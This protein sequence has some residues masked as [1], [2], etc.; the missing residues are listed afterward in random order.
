MLAALSGFV[1]TST[2]PIA[3]LLWGVLLVALSW[4]LR[5]SK[6]AA[7]EQSEAAAPEEAADSPMVVG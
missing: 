3:I 2:E 4:R 7:A 5:S 1:I 6:T